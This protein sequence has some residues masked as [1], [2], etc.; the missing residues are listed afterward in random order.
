MSSKGEA[1]RG[2]GGVMPR[3]RSIMPHFLVIVKKVV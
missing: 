1:K 3:F 2:I